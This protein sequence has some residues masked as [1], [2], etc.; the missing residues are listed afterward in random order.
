MRDLREFDHIRDIVG[1]RRMGIRSESAK[2]W[3]GV[4]QMPVRS[5]RKPLLIIASR[6]DDPDY[7]T[8]WDHVSVSLPTRCPDWG[9]MC[10]VKDTFFL[11]TERAFQLHPL[12]CE[13]ISNHRYCLHLWRPCDQDI[14][15]PPSLMVGIKELGDLGNPRKVAV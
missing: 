6:G 1:E 13:N 9:E 4:F 15:I 11:P 5:A 7:W 2:P 3:G 8:G 10:M 12:A 14:P